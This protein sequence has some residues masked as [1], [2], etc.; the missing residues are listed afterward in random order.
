MSDIDWNK[1]DTDFVRIET[2]AA[3]RLK[4]TNWR[5][6]SWFNMTGIRFEVTEE[7][8]KKVSKVFTTTSKRLIRALKPFIMKAET[9]KETVVSIS[10][11]R[12]GEGL[13]TF[14]EVKALVPPSNRGSEQRENV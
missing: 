8:S 9:Q 5:Q 3:K 1:F 10:I 13:N 4:L 7:D 11:L 14:Y 12:V 2:S 6:G